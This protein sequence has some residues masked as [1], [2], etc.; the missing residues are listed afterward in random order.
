MARQRTLP[1]L[2]LTS[3]S[4]HS[5]NEVLTME[6]KFLFF[7]LILTGGFYA[8]AEEPNIVSEPIYGGIFAAN[9]IGTAN[10]D[11]AGGATDHDKSCSCSCSAQGILLRECGDETENLGNYGNIKNCNKQKESHPQCN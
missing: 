7:I 3:A 6:F 5:L 2:C 11:H 10:I 1:L 4:R 9:T 8:Y